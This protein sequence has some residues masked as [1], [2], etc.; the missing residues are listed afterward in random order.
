MKL[1]FGEI[2]PIVSQYLPLVEGMAFPGKEKIVSFAERLIH[3]L[4]NHQQPEQIAEWV[5]WILKETYTPAP[6]YSQYCETV[7][8]QIVQCMHQSLQNVG[9]AS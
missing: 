6:S 5:Y 1:L 2:A 4:I 8:N 3:T 9:N 7:I